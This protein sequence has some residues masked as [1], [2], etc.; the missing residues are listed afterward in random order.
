MLFRSLMAYSWPGNVRELE[1]VL[2]Q[3]SLL[4]T[5]NFIRFSDLP[6]RITEPGQPEE[7]QSRDLSLD[8]VTRRHIAFVLE[9]CRGN[10]TRAA[11]A[12][13]ISRRSIL[14]KIEKYSIS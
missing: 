11:K 13:G 4:T 3:A 9:S 2:E 14:R 1:N 8:T 7:S 6:E 5:E 12:L 10:R